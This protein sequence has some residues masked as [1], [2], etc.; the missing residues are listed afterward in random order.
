MI[1]KVTSPDPFPS[2]P[3]ASCLYDM[4]EICKLA[5]KQ[6][7]TFCHYP[8]RH[9]RRTS[10]LP[11]IQGNH[12]D[13]GHE[14]EERRKHTTRQFLWPIRDLNT[15]DSQIYITHRCSSTRITTHPSPAP[16]LYPK[17]KVIMSCTHYFIKVYRCMTR[18]IVKCP[19]YFPSPSSLKLW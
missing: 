13:Q 18:S 5:T 8:P 14:N 7:L 1:A 15:S 17:E 4:Y 6:I 3:S 12:V 16:S 10:L 2:S 19:M 9:S 11:L